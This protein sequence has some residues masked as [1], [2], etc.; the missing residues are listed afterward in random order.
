MTV[1]RLK[2]DMRRRAAHCHSLGPKMNDILDGTLECLTSHLHAKWGDRAP[3]DVFNRLLAKNIRPTGWTKNT[4]A[5]LSRDQ[6]ASRKEQWTTASLGELTRGHGSPTGVDV[7]CPIILAEHEGVRVLDGN[8]RINRWVA[9][10]DTRRHV[11]HIHAITGP[12]RFIELPSVV[13]LR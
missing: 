11:V 6:I 12:I 8:H 13:S 4:H 7:A 1:S 9:S 2:F 10:A 5:D 3:L